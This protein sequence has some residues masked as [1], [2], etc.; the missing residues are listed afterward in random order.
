MTR[1]RKLSAK[2]L[3][4]LVMTILLACGFM[5]GCQEK[6]ELAPEDP[7]SILTKLD[8]EQDTQKVV[9]TALAHVQTLS[10]ANPKAY[11][12]D[13]RQTTEHEN[14]TSLLTDC[15]I[16]LDNGEFYTVSILYPGYTVGRSYLETVESF[17]PLDELTGDAFSGEYGVF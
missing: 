4:L 15:H 7:L 10:D 11:Y 5:T 14:A 2:A 3:A 13:G 16:L 12:L 6:T 9:D 17:P 1:K 8:E